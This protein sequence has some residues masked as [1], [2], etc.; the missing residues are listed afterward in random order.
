MLLLRVWCDV[1]W[2]VRF[3]FS[4]FCVVLFVCFCVCFVLVSWFAVVVGRV[5]SF[6]VACML[7]VWV[8][9]CRVLL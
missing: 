2:C 7:F 6:V 5:R 8:F 9:I 3:F 4:I 1:V